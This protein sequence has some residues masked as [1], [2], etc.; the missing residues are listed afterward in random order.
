M[1]PM[2]LADVAGRHLRVAVPA[3]LDQDLAA[4]L[5]VVRAAPAVLEV[6]D[7]AGRLAPLAVG[8]FLLVARR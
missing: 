6:G 5:E 2:V 4:D 3:G 8:L 7:R 1:L